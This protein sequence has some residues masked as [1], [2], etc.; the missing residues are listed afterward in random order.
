[1]YPRRVSDPLASAISA[2]HATA[3]AAWPDVAV[4]LARF[5]AE[6]R[7]RLGPELSVEEL[8]K[9]VTTDVYLAI[10]CTDGDS[11]AAAHLEREHFAEVDI[12]DRKSTRLNSSH[13]V[14]SRMPSSA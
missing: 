12:A 10:A 14:V 1:M 3:R 6:L 4:E 9:I 2:A 11:R 7:R 8:A 5:D 13:A